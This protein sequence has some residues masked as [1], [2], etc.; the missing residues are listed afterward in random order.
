AFD[1]HPDLPRWQEQGV[2][3]TLLAGALDGRQ[4]PCRLYS[5]LLGADLA[6]HDASTL[7]LT[8]DPHFEYGLLPLEGG[9]E[10]GGEHF[11]VNELAYLGD[12][13]DGLQLQLDPGARVLLLGGAPFGAEIFMWWNFVGHSKGE[14]ARAQKAWEEGDARFGRLDALEGPRLSAPPIPW[15]IDAE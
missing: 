11:A 2:T 9:L 1:H 6:C 7:Q 10:V 14:I 13:R 8:L 12:G 4:A 15:K 5:P 3:F